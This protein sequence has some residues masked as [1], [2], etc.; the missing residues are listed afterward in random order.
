MAVIA[1][2]PPHNIE[3]EESILGSILIDPS[4]ITRVAQHISPADFFIVKNRWVYEAFLRLKDQRCPIDFRTVN[5]EI[6]NASQL[7][8]MGGPAFI[9]H[10]VNVTPAALHAEGYAQIVKKLSMRRALLELASKIAASAFDESNSVRDAVT[11]ASESLH[12]ITTC[13]PRTVSISQPANALQDDVEFY[14]E[15][16]IGPDAVRGFSL[17]IIHLDRLTGGLQLDDMTVITARP[18]VGKTALVLQSADVLATNGKRVLI[19]SLEMRAKRLLRRMASRRAH[20]DWKRVDR[21]WAT[22]DELARVM[23]ELGNLAEL[24]IT[25]NDDNHITTAQIAAEVEQTRPDLVIVDNINI[26]LEPAAY[27]NE[28]DVKRIGRVSRN[29]KIIANDNYIPVVCI[30]HMNR[31]SEGRADKRPTLSDLRESGEI[32]QNAD[33]VLGMYR[34]MKGEQQAAN[35]VEV[36]PLKLRDGDTSRPVKFIYEG[37]FYEFTAAETGE[38]RL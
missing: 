33:N 6:A 22:S 31:Q 37:V 30:A 3:A 27:A 18:G 2:L 14:S 32:E 29:L 35:I 23:Y 20:V 7:D 4:C 11:A 38:V 26:M 24:P 36:W 8:E 5:V 19:Y 15:N 12:K 16:P 1:S 28:N 9:S 21:G 34:D 25:I 13:S 10:L 17:G